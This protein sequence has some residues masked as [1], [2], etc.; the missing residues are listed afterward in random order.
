MGCGKAPG[1]R[2]RVSGPA[3]VATH[4]V[5]WTLLLLPENC[6]PEGLAQEPGFLFPLWSLGY[7]FLRDLS[8]LVWDRVGSWEGA[9][10]QMQVR[11][12]GWVPHPWEHVEGREGP[13]VFLAP[14]SGKGLGPQP[15][16]GASPTSCLTLW[17]FQFCPS[18]VSP[19]ARGR[20]WGA[21]L[22][23]K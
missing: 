11:G 15:G 13:C 7:F 5:A 22:H 20:G 14:S 19:R 6:Q 12:K 9:G 21:L 18:T 16:L 4:L 23:L 3:L 10:G 17:G 1:N 2:L 8:I